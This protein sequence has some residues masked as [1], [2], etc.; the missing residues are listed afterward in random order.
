MNMAQRKLLVIA[1]G[2]WVLAVVAVAATAVVAQTYHDSAQ[3]VR[4]AVAG[5][6]D[7]EAEGH[8]A[9]PATTF[10]LASITSGPDGSPFIGTRRVSRIG[11]ADGGH[12]LVAAVARLVVR[13]EPGDTVVKLTWT[14]PEGQ[15]VRAYRIYRKGAPRSLAQVKQPQFE[16]IGLSNGTT[17][18]YEVVAVLLDGTEWKG[19][20]P[21]SVTPGDP[22]APGPPIA[23]ARIRLEVASWVPAR[24]IHHGWWGVVHAGAA[25]DQDQLV[26]STNTQDALLLPPGRYDVY[27]KQDYANKPILLA[28]EVEVE[29]GREET[30]KADSAMRLE[31]ASWVP[32]RAIHHGWWGVVHA[33]AAPDQ[34]QLVQ[35]TNTQDALLLPPGRYDIY[36]KQEYR[37]PP[38]LLAR[39]VQV[40]L[41]TLARVS[42]KSGIKLAFPAK[43]PVLEHHFGWWGVVPTGAVPENLIHLSGD[44]SAPLLV[45]SGRYDVYWKQGGQS[46]PVLLASRVNVEPDQLTTVTVES[47]IRLEVSK[48]L[49]SLYSWEVI[50]AGQP[51]EVVQRQSG[52]TLES[53]VPPGDYQV[54]FQPYHMGSGQVVWPERVRA[55]PG[56]WTPVKVD[57]GIKLV[58]PPEVAAVYAWSV[59]RAGQQDRV[60]QGYHDVMGGVLQGAKWRVMLVPPG[61]YDIYWRQNSSQQPQRIKEAVT[62]QEHELHEVLILL[63]DQSTKTPP[64]QDSR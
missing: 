6:G 60:V 45:P 57:S 31:V 20:K 2:I 29:S 25:P 28:S 16:D 59:V 26:Q 22:K 47:G 50:K 54:A 37:N 38:M 12:M 17:Y 55:E 41:G 62:V 56:Q 23:D 1:V 7:R 32:A 18:T 35:S 4:N 58:L 46:T 33:G 44:T 48:E 14:P 5:G 49:K 36:W 8:S 51:K 42:A 34:D 52:T 10:G 21:V 61:T 40:E 43:P 3:P 30:V 63:P 64:R 53:R 19:Y 11:Q 13:A 27:W 15:E 39:G 24:A 9:T